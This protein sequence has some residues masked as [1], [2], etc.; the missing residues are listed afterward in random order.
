MPAAGEAMSVMSAFFDGLDG[1]SALWR[2][3]TGSW[4]VA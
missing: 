4:L 2:G 3:W 1:E